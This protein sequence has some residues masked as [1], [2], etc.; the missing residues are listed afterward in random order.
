MKTLKI[1]Q[2]KHITPTTYCVVQVINTFNY[3]TDKGYINK[4]YCYCN[5]A[6]TKV[7]DVIKVREYFLQ[8]Y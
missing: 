4:N 2:P 5:S 8:R 6:T 3:K 1:N 7:G